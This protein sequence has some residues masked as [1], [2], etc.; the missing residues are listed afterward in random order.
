VKSII[1]GKST[2][3][4]GKLYQKKIDGTEE[5][6]L[7]YYSSGSAQIVVRTILRE[8]LDDLAALDQAAALTAG[9]VPDVDAVRHLPVDVAQDG[10]IHPEARIRLVQMVPV[11]LPL[12]LHR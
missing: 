11:E 6:I 7:M 4:L 8:T 10:A 2:Y 12:H 1:N 9:D 3:Y 5:T